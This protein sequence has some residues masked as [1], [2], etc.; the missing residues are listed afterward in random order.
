MYRA[1]FFP[2][3]W[4]NDQC[5]EIKKSFQRGAGP[6]QLR[7]GFTCVFCRAVTSQEFIPSP[8]FTRQ[9][10]IKWGMHHMGSNAL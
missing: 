4:L 2:W 10:A 1:K 9:T 8:F 7:A 5:M 6:C 3:K